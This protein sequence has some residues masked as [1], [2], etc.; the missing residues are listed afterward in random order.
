MSLSVGDASDPMRG[1]LSEGIELGSVG[2]CGSCW[3]VA[4]VSGGPP[5]SGQP[6]SGFESPSG[7]ES[8]TEPELDVR[9]DNT[10]TTKA[11]SLDNN[12]NSCH[13]RIRKG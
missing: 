8:M 12:P 7:M 2:L 6:R 1:W 5:L 4:N 3:G 9:N 13:Y 11:L 10:I